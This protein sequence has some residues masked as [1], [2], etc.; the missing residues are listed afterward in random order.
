MTIIAVSPELK[1]EVNPVNTTRIILIV[2]YDGTR[3]HGFQAQAGLATIQSELETAIRQLTGE[4]GRLVTASRTDAGVHARG[5]VVSFRTESDLPAETFVTGLN[6]YLP[7]DIAVKSAHKPGNGFHIWHDVQSREYN[8]YI[9]NSRIRSPLRRGFYHRVAGQLNIEAMNQACRAL[10]GEN[11]F[12]SFVS[13][14]EAALKST[15]K[16]VDRAEVKR[17]GDLVIFNILANSFLMHQVRNT[18]GPLVR[19]G[20]GKMSVAEFHGLL[21]RKQPGLARPAAPACGLCLMEINYNNPV[22]EKI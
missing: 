21:E 5:Q 7:D 13:P 22:E 17:E 15:V 12:A 11:D 1:Q 20:R 4:S 2:E 18:V 8:Y 10:I 16:R 9:L 19:V 3:Y 14:D 6:Y